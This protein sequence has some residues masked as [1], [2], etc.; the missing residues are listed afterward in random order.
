MGW[1]TRHVWH[2]TDW[3][4]VAANPEMLKFPQPAWLLGSDATEYA[5]DNFDAVISHLDDGTPFQSKNIPP[6]H[7]HK[8]WTID[9]MLSY[10]GKKASKD[11]YQT[12]D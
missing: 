8:D 6:G 7:V 12:R 4:A 1:E 5:K 11:F 3:D 2:Q 9:M 10:E